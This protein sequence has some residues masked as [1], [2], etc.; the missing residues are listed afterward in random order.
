MCR[1]TLPESRYDPDHLEAWRRHRDTSR[2][3]V[4]LQCLKRQS[5]TAPAEGEPETRTRPTAPE[6]AP[7]PPKASTPTSPAATATGGREPDADIP[8]SRCR[9]TLPASGYDP[10]RVHIWEQRQELARR[11]VC[12]ECR[13]S[14]GP[15]GRLPS[16]TFRCGQC[17]RPLP[18]ESFD[19][20]ELRRLCGARELWR[21]QC[22]ACGRVAASATTAGATAPRSATV[23]WR[24]R[25]CGQ[26]KPLAAFSDRMQRRRQG[27]HTKC[28]DCQ[29]P[30]CAA[31]GERPERIY[32]HPYTD[33][34]YF[35]QR[36]AYPPCAG[37]CGRPRPSTS[38]SYWHRRRMPTWFCPECRA[39]GR[40]SEA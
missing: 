19:L 29:H 7:S 35:C 18:H 26:T 22:E 1:E 17:K 40:G 38:S 12:E 37:G 9:R 23:Q 8:C 6:A 16:A 24:C 30:R 13:R 27:A 28:H 3:A 11:A 5:A 21:L 10:L 39:A 4:C 31:C 36:C 34:D 32:D 15:G 2:R 20:G 25:R 14:Q 33:G